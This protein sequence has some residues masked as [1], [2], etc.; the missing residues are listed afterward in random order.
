MTQ[1]IS[2]VPFQLLDLALRILALGC[3]AGIVLT[4]FRVRATLLRLV[5]WKGVLYS[6]LAMPLLAWILP[7]L[8]I[9]VPALIGQRANLLSVQPEENAHI[10]ATRFVTSARANESTVYKTSPEMR[11]E[12]TR[13]ESTAGTAHSRIIITPP[14]ANAA[15]VTDVRQHPVIPWR[16]LATV[17]YFVVALGLLVRVMVGIIFS[18]RL[19]RSSAP[20]SAHR[21]TSRIS[22]GNGL[23]LAK[24]VESARVS[25]PV[26]IGILRSR[27]IL[28]V[29]WHEWENAKLD[30][31][32][33]HELSHVARRDPLA[34]FLSLLHRATFWFSPLAWW[35][36]RHL[37]SLAEQASDEAALCCGADRN[38]YAR[39]LLGFFETLHATPGRVWWQ[40]VSM[41]KAGQA[42][43]RLE[44][45]LAWKG[46]VTM[47]LKKS[48]IIA[49][50]ALALPAAYLT[51]AVHAAG[52]QEPQ[53]PPPA[54]QASAPR[55]ADDFPVP[56]AE[57]D[58]SPI[59]AVPAAPWAGQTAV[60]PVSPREPMAAVDAPLP[61]A[62]VAPAA[63]IR[64]PAPPAVWPMQNHS[65]GAGRSSGKGFSYAFGYD[66]EQR[67]VIVTGNS[68]SMTMSGSSEDARHVERLKKQIPGDFIWFSRDEKSYIIR[69]QATVAR[70]RA[71]WAP[72]EEL[73]K[74][75]EELGKRQEELGKRQEELGNQQE[76]LG[77]KQEEVRVKVP[78]MTAE[79]DRLKAKI[80]KLGPT[81]TMEQIGDLQSEI[82]DL[83]SKIGEIQSEAGDQQGKLGE[84]QGALG[85]KQ[86]E[87]GEQQGKLGDEQA[88]L[89]EKATLQMKALLDESIKNG[90][91]QPEPQSGGGTGT[92]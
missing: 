92:L 6:A 55:S 33:A 31:V 8:P 62:A 38:D 18:H 11:T 60:A 57:P 59:P 22:S 43:K 68:D 47:N 80:Q 49:L 35:L 17:I 64:P 73:G 34:Q 10:V 69:D 66:D 42:E 3:A 90:T 32:L 40:G 37:A 27:I 45:I 63:A 28:P 50:F 53:V 75:Q 1:T 77:K 21:V 48:V 30:A 54:P 51:A 72:Q 82:G 13:T 74:K 65:Y 83:Q 7:P 20:V 58:A 16:A 85:E 26:T 36:D 29:D 39:V 91:A 23:P 12:E 88:K 4:V 41:A 84:E 87:L 52:P 79:L 46:M 9:S 14:S 86:G 81:A 71:F 78:D 19:L 15:L 44:R 61:P 76:A 24:V 89:A 2:A 25:V 56:A 70:A 67:F 5:T